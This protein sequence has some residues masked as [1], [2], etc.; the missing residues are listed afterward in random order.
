MAGGNPCKGFLTNEGDGRGEMDGGEVFAKFKGFIAYGGDTIGNGDGFQGFTAVECR[1]ADG[2][3]LGGEEDL[4]QRGTIAEHEFADGGQLVGETDG[5]E[6]AATVEDIGFQCCG[7][8]CYNCGFQACTLVE[9]K[10]AD[11]MDGGGD[12][13]GFQAFTLGE[14]V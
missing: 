1:A 14:G 11:G 5:G 3:Q 6:G 4:F 7:A 8:A 13:D 9:C 10:L 12:G 2:I